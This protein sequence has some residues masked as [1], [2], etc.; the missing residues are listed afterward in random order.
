MRESTVSVS[1]PQSPHHVLMCGHT[2]HVTRHCTTTHHTATH[3]L[4][5]GLNKLRLLLKRSPQLSLLTNLHQ[6]KSQGTHMY[7]EDVDAMYM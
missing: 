2:Y 6:V 5:H 1:P 4:S 7:T 3:L